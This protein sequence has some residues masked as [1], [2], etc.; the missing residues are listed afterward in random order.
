MD[1]L[2]A[3]A[4]TSAA[5]A[6]DRSERGLT[7]IPDGGTPTII[8]FIPPPRKGPLRVRRAAHNVDAEYLKKY[9]KGIELMKALPADDPLSFTRQMDLYHAYRDGA[10]HQ[11]GLPKLDLQGPNSR[12]FFP[13]HRC[14]LYFF[15]RI[16]SNLIG[17]D[18][19][20]LPFW[21]RDDPERK[22]VPDFY[23]KNRDPNNQKQKPIIHNRSHDSNPSFTERMEDN[24]KYMY[25]SM[26][27]IGKSAGLFMGS[28][29]G[30][31]E[32]T[33]YPGGGS[34]GQIPHCPAHVW[35]E[36]QAMGSFNYT[37]PNWNLWACYANVDRIWSAWE[38]QGCVHRIDIVD[39]DLLKAYFYFYDENRQIVRIKV[40]DCLD[41]EK[42]GFR[43]ETV[44]LKSD[45]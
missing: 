7:E 43:Y 5:Q 4:L 36:E 1:S 9:V 25:R 38:A 17:D 15:E 42:L 21:S 31:G 33:N 40:R 8:D 28:P 37:R 35:I 14:Y 27:L 22:V 12:F 32:E 24:L 19:F 41:T 16:L 13:W 30:E 6:P 3:A 20:S 10:Y 18:E 23:K 44:E 39:P 26:T 11:V 34:I 45:V 29:N 2:A